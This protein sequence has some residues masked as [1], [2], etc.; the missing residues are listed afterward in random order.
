M[1]TTTAPDGTTVGYGHDGGGDRPPVVLV[2]E[3]G[4]GAW[5]WAWQAPALAGP[6]PVVVAEYRGG[7]RSGPP[8]DDCDLATLAGDV[9]AI[10]ADAGARRPHVVGFGLGGLVALSLALDGEVRS[11]CLLGS[12]A[13]GRGVDPSPLFAPP[14]DPGALRASLDAALSPEFRERHPDVCDQIVAWRRDDDPS[15]A[16]ARRQAAALD[17][18]VS[19]RLVAVTTPALV[20]HGDADAVWPVASAEDLAENLPRGDRRRVAGAGHLV[21]CEA[22]APVND[23]LVGFVERVEDESDG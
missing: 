6:R 17:V 4:F 20:V 1:P 10:L 8:A 14:G 5:Q 9:R 3:C 18:D 11:L 13:S 12:G 16:V 21:G 23:A 2:G 15:P 7:T 19:D 22:A